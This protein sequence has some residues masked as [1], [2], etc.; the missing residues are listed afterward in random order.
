MRVARV[1]VQLVELPFRF[2][3]GHALAARS[4]STNVI[5]TVTLDDGATSTGAFFTGE[6]VRHNPFTGAGLV[7]A[8][9]ATR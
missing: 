9:A 8:A 5:V 7:N 4:S 2:T 3:F 6:T 1:E